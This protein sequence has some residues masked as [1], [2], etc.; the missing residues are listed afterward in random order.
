MAVSL[1]HSPNSDPT[2]STIAII[3]LGGV[4]GVAAGCLI[5]AGRRVFACIRRP[6]DRL[7]L[8]R[9]E[10]SV[11][12]PLRALTDPTKAPSVD[13]VL[14]CTKAYSTGSAVPWL[15]RLCGSSTRVAVLQNGID[16]VARVAPLARGAT[17]IPAIVY[18]NGER[19]APDR[20][21]LRHVAE[22]DLAV[23][24]DPPGRDF[25]RLFQGTSLNVQ[26]SDDFTTLLWRKLLINAVAN[27][28]TTLTRQRQ[29]VLRREDIR[30]LSLAVLD[31]AVAVA[32]A[33]G[34]GVE[35]EEAARILATLL[36]YPEGA[37]SSM[38]FDCLAGRPLECE[39]LNGAIVAAGERH[40]VATPLN[41]ALV[42]LLRA[43][44]AA[45]VGADDR[46]D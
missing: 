12:L 21:R 28:I 42:A 1:P 18:Y 32:R 19:V 27:P 24:D 37:G 36:T 43:I 44:S 39:A 25:V 15:E 35:P 34:A 8:E 41:R 38:Y 6:L 20:F 7:T 40:G 11:D 46:R 2:N 31:E 26:S 33:E 16:H 3:G 23:P 30:A 9:P 14:L 29:A 22:Y 17:V 45:A 10:G 4:G 5:G 13:W